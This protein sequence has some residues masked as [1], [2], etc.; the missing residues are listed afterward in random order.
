MRRLRAVVFDLWGTLVDASVEEF[1]GLRRRIAERAGIDEERFEAV[2]AETYHLR[3]TGPILP[4]LRAVG[5]PDDTVPDVL[6]W[7]REVTRRCLVPRDDAPELLAELRRRGLRIGL[8]SMCT[9]EVA[10]LWQKTSLAPLVEEPVFSC[11]VGLAKP[12][13]RIYELACRRLGVAAEEALFVGDGANDELAGADRAGMRAVLL[14]G[15]GEHGR[16]WEGERI[17]ALADLL[18]LIDAAAS[19]R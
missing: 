5:L 2:W 19:V 6:A 18:P 7:R 17:P 12:D 15:S 13:P 11:E 16:H 10:E 8:I 1:L 3:E 9:Q 14:D 4:A